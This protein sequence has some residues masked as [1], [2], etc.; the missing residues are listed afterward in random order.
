MTSFDEVCFWHQGIIAPI[1]SSQH[2]PTMTTPGETSFDQNQT[3]ME[4]VESGTP[5]FST[6]GKGQIQESNDN[7]E[8]TSKKNT[9][10]QLGLTISAVDWVGVA[11]QHTH[12]FSSTVHP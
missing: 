1:R 8:G 4:E 5:R 3:G 6:R 11:I 7:G 12:I 9:L 10:V 2:Y